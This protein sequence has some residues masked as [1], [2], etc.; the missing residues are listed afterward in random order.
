MPSIRPF[1]TRRNAFT[2]IEVLATLVLVA[3]VLPAVM[4]GMSMSM[5][6]A[7]L[8]RDTIEAVQL[9]D[10]KLNEIIAM[11]QTL[12]G[13]SAGDF[14]TDYPQY[15]WSVQSMQREQNLLEIELTVTWPWRND[16]RSVTVST[17]L[18]M[19]TATPETEMAQ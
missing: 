14:G 3:I 8:A 10:A 18:F 17:L 7:A 16:Q 6:A 4:Q 11:D 13:A 2:L 12:T 1:S 9:A 5:G 19:S 15:Q